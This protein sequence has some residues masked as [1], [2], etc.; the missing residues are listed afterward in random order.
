MTYVLSCPPTLLLGGGGTITKGYN[1]HGAVGLYM[2]GF[3]IW[4]CPLKNKTNNN[5]CKVWI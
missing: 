2:Y 1:D 4:C 3:N 5:V